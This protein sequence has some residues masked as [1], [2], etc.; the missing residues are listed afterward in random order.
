MNGMLAAE[1]PSVAVTYTCF[2]FLSERTVF[3]SSM[4]Y[5]YRT[6]LYFDAIL[7]H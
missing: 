5:S 7:S 1:S 6:T 2:V 4:H 3:Y